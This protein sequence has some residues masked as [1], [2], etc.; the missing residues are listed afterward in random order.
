[1]GANRKLTT[2][3]VFPDVAHQAELEKHQDHIRLDTKFPF[4]GANGRLTFDLHYKNWIPHI[5][6]NNPSSCKTDSKN[7]G[8]QE[9][10]FFDWKKTT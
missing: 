4:Y 5:R 9:I 2:F 3:Q 7:E 10:M 1:M 8:Y 6:I